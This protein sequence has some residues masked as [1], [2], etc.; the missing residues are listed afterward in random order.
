LTEDRLPLVELLQK[1]GDDDFIRAVAEAV[2]W[3]LPPGAA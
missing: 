3:I 2:L 1:A